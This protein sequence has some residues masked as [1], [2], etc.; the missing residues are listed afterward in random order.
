MFLIEH[1]F[2]RGS[3]DKTLFIKQDKRNI[4][5]AQVYVDDIVFS[6]SS[7]LLYD[8]FAEMMAQEFE[9]SMV[10]NL[11][12]CLGLQ[13]KKTESGIFISQPKYA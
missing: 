4:L 6:S 5:I 10:G 1:G 9:V 2:E 3:V 13:I 8:K 11:S 12:F 7:E